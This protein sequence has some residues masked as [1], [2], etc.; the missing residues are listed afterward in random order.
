MV[1]ID[2]AYLTSYEGVTMY[3][4]RIHFMA[5]VLKMRN[6]RKGPLQTLLKQLT[7]SLIY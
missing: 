1:I 5:E 3:S 7:N 4:I 2:R 6:I